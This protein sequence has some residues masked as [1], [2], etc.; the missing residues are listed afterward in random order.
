MVEMQGSCSEYQDL[1]SD[2]R[3]FFS[4]GNAYQVSRSLSYRDV[5]SSFFNRRIQEEGLRTYLFTYAPHYSTLSLSLLSRTFSLT[6]RSVTSIVSKMIWNEELS[7]SL[8]HATG[9]LVFHRVEV[10]RSHQLAQILADKVNTMVEQNEKALDQKLGNTANWND[11]GDGQKGDKRGE[12]TQERRRGG[13]RRG[14][15]RGTYFQ[16]LLAY[17]ELI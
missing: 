6:L 9:V 2:A 15:I 11:R 3:S 5:L 8:D 4:E 14:G 17:S 7:A 13:E 10:T 1:E 12:Q 16:L